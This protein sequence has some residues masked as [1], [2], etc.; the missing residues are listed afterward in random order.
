MNKQLANKV[1][2]SIV[3]ALIFVASIKIFGITIK[4]I[5]S[6]ENNTVILGLIAEVLCIVTTLI[7]LFCTH[8][9]NIVKGTMSGFAKGISAGGFLCGFAVLLF[10][11]FF[12]YDFSV[13]K[14]LTI[15]NIMIYLFSMLVTGFTEEVVFRGV[16][17]NTISECFDTYSK[18]NVYISMIISSIIFGLMHMSNIFS[19]VSL[20]GAIVQAGCAFGVG[21]YFCAIYVRCNN[22]WSVIV[23]HGLNDIAST[24][25]A[26]VLGESDIVSNVSDYSPLKLIVMVLYIGLAMYVL[27]DS[28]FRIQDMACDNSNL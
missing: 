11:S 10:I 23:L 6:D 18:K 27:R 8:K 20:A 15:S 21:L 3:I 13:E 4:A 19:G 25:N 17:Y 22:I 7:I 2:T 24:L 1:L 14:V 28:K 5:S 26:G 9:Q 12:V 16:I